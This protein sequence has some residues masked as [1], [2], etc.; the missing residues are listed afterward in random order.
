MSG[1][2]LPLQTLISFFHSYSL[3]A[4]LHSIIFPLFIPLP[5]AIPFIWRSAI[6]K[7][8]WFQGWDLDL[9]LFSHQVIS[10]S[11]RPHG[12]QCTWLA[13]PSPSPVVCPS[14][15]SLTWWCHPTI[16]SSKTVNIYSWRR[17]QWWVPQS[18]KVTEKSGLTGLV[19]RLWKVWVLIS[20]LALY[21]DNPAQGAAW[22]P[23]LS[24]RL[25]VALTFSLQRVAAA[26][27][28]ALPRLLYSCLPIG[29]DFIPGGSGPSS[30]P[31]ASQIQLTT[32]WLSPQLRAGKCSP[33]LSV[34]IFL[35]L[36]LVL[37]T[38]LT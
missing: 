16:S 13:C 31:L 28:C 21:R 6:P 27:A 33:C 17:Y 35:S 10:D 25:E 19:N 37:G 7:S 4:S 8:C 3:T 2:N 22:L 18:S 20:S 36:F 12:L 38:C 5:S 14:S 24:V 9:L 15:S 1:E 29:S 30:M 26:A 32:V 23:S 34:S 11:S